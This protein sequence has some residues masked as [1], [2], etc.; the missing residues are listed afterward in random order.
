MKKINGEEQKKQK[1]NVSKKIH[2]SFFLRF[3]TSIYTNGFYTLTAGLCYMPLSCD[4]D[5]NIC[6]Q[7]SRQHPFPN[8]G[9]FLP[10]RWLA[11]SSMV[12]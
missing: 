8:G 2:H 6:G 11:F 10:H 4:H 3:V 5:P 7:Y 9:T 12:R 1:T